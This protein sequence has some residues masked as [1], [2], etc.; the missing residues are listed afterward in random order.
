MDINAMSFHLRESKIHI[1]E[2]KKSSLEIEIETGN[3]SEEEV[4]SKNS[5]ISELEEKIEN[6][7]NTINTDVIF[8]S[9]G[10]LV[11][12]TYAKRGGFYALMFQL[13]AID[14]TFIDSEEFK[15]IVAE[16]GIDEDAVIKEIK[17]N[18]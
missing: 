3:L 16:L 5:E 2:S 12:K 8:H 17:D 6:V 10:K 9:L 15:T 13:A 4:T 18:L 11:N 1:L 7:E 14:I